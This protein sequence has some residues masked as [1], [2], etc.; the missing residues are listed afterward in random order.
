[1]SILKAGLSTDKPDM[2]KLSLLIDTERMLNFTCF[3]EFKAQSTSH[4]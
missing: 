2:A 4:L 1:M 3:V